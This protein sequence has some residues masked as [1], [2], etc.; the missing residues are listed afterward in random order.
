MVGKLLSLKTI[1]L[2]S[3]MYVLNIQ[4]ENIFWGT[5]LCA[6]VYVHE[7]VMCA[8]MCTNGLI[9]NKIPALVQKIKHSPPMLYHFSH[10]HGGT[11]SHQMMV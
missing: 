9:V 5:C 8:R 3:H 6:S 7:C 4:L 1:K 11:V 10:K 2:D